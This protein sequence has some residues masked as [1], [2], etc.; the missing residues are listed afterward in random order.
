MSPTSFQTTLKT[1]HKRFP[2][3]FFPTTS[4][5]KYVEIILSDYFKNKRRDPQDSFELLQQQNKRSPR[6][7]FKLTSKTGTRLFQ[8]TSKTKQGIPENLPNYFKNKT[9]VVFYFENQAQKMIEILSNCF[10]NETQVVLQ[11]LSNY[12]QNK[13]IDPRDS[14]NYLK[15]Q[16]HG[17][18]EILSNYFGNQTQGV[19]EIVPNYF[20]N[21]T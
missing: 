16:A 19:P 1:K 11:I 13:T 9:R 10:K 18:F 17:L 4:K 7:S 6:D 20:R 21:K 8:I 5:T 15:N 2:S 3:F 14:S 12:F